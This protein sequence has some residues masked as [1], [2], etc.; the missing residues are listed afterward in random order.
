[1][2]FVRQSLS[3]LEVLEDVEVQWSPEQWLCAYVIYHAIRDL[4]VSGGRL[5]DAARAR[6][7]KSAFAWIMN[8]D[9]GGNSSHLTFIECC[10][11]IEASSQAIRA[12]LR[13]EGVSWDT[14]AEPPPYRPLRRFVMWGGNRGTGSQE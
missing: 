1:M 8:D 5:S 13:R 14:L 11:A 12:V 9:P 3:S 2:F 10:D 4:S 7:R 6:I